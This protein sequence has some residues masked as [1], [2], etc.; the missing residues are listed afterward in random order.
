MKTPGGMKT[1]GG[2]GFQ[3][4]N[5]SA[6][7]ASLR[8]RSNSDDEEMGFQFLFTGEEGGIKTPR[9]SGFQ[10]GNGSVAMASSR[11]RFDNDDE[12]M[13]FQFSFG[14]KKLELI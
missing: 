4:R 5:G 9:D 1:L 7:M 14:E 3:H 12:E 8:R 10:H 6:A 13:G 2:Y 11:R